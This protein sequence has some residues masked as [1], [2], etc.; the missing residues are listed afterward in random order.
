MQNSKKILKKA[1]TKKALSNLYKQ[2]RSIVTVGKK[3]GTYEFKTAKTYDRNRE[4]AK[5]KKEM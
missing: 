3:L 1:M 2:Q 4:K 5:L